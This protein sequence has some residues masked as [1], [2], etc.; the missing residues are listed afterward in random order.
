MRLTTVPLSHISVGQS[1]VIVRCGLTGPLRR[2]LF[3]L[4]MLTGETVTI[5]RVA[6][7]GDPLELEIKGYR[8]SLRKAEAGQI[9]VA[10]RA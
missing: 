5:T 3:A 9:L 2:P 8:L 6:P 4:G 7:L 1:A 10:P